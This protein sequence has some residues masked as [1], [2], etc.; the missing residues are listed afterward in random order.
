[1]TFKSIEKNKL[2]EP[3]IHLQLLLH[4]CFSLYAQCCRGLAPH[5]GGEA[6]GKQPCCCACGLSSFWCY[7]GFRLQWSASSR[8]TN[9]SALICTK[10]HSDLLT[11]DYSVFKNTH[12]KKVFFFFPWEENM[13]PILFVFWILASGQ[14]SE[15]TRGNN[16]TRGEWLISL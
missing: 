6:K 5:S 13:R 16:V 11:R 4:K 10:S 15:G 9:S 3:P 12:T 14:H 7:I 8:F 1:M 2:C